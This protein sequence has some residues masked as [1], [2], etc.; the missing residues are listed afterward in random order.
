[1][2]HE[3]SIESSISSAESRDA[4]RQRLIL[5]EARL[6]NQKKSLILAFFLWFVLGGLGAHNFYLNRAIQ[7]VIKILLLVLAFPS[8]GATFIILVIWWV[9]DAFFLSSWIAADTE[10]KRRQIIESLTFKE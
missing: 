6:A 10:V 4:S 9:I 3:S 5:A 1:M 7:G 2:S 8:G